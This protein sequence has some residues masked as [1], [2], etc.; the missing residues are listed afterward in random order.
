MGALRFDLVF[1]YWI[2]AWFLLYFFKFTNNSPKFIIIIGIIHNSIL[3]LNM[4]IHGTK[5]FSIISF[6]T[7]NV[8]IKILPLYYL[9]NEKIKVD[10][11]Y[12]SSFVY[13]LFVVWL[14]INGEDIKNNLKKI[15]NSVLYDKNNTPFM[16]LVEY[17]RILSSKK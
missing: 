10:D 2:F 5:I 6:I 17:I 1:S 9:R 8:F 3:L 15:Y 14:K 12:V 7:I 11:I 4:I 13:L 16:R